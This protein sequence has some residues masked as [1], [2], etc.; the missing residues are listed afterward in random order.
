[1]KKTLLVLSL[2]LAA[3]VAGT[4]A[5]ANTGTINF[6]G[7]ITAST[8]P[9]EIV[10]PADGSIGN[11]VK[12]GNVE[13]SRFTAVG[14][15]HGG[16]SFALRV[17]DNSGCNITPTSKASVTF[18]GTADP[19]GNYFA[20]T[21]TADAAKGAVIALKDRTGIPLV[22]G[23]SSADYDLNDSGS[24]DLPF[25]ATYRSTALVVTAGMASADVQFVVD[26]N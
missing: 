18:N 13:A 22:P 5:F 12:M 6:E 16:K 19:S 24:T 9:I 2:G 20:L 8:C 14:Q 10:N 11:Q 25:Y 21:P 3:G 1:L 4:S 15:E 23:S 7:R 26:I 17:P